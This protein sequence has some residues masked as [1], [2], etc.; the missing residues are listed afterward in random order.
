ML[1]ELDRL[2]TIAAAAKA[3]HLTAPGVSMQLAALERE[4][5]DILLDRTARSA[6]LTDAGKAPVLA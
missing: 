5:G 1:A 3:L 4:A 2:G 6:E